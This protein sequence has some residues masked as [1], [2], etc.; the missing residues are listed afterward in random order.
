M[1]NEENIAS[2]IKQRHLPMNKLQTIFQSQEL[3]ILSS[4]WF[5]LIWGY[6]NKYGILQDFEELPLIPIGTEQAFKEVAVLRKSSLIIHYE[7]DEEDGVISLLRHL[8]C[9]IV[10]A[11]PSYVRQNR[12]VFECKY[13]YDYKDEDLLQL[14]S[15]LSLKLGQD[16][17]IRKFSEFSGREVKLEFFRKVSNFAVKDSM[18]TLIKSLPFIENT[19]DERL[20][21]VEQCHLIAP[22]ELPDVMPQQM[23]LRIQHEVQVSFIEKLGGRQLNKREFI[24]A[25]L[26]PEINKSIVPYGNSQSMINY[27]LDIIAASTDKQQWQKVINALSSVR[28]VQSDDGKL[29]K[30]IELFRR[31]ERLEKLFVGEKGLFPNIGQNVQV[32]KLKNVS[33]VSAD[34]IRRS[35]VPIHG[36]E[37]IHIAQDK[38]RRVLEHLEHYSNLLNDENLIY[39]LTNTSWIPINKKRPDAY[40]DSLT[41][42]GENT[43]CNFG[44][45]AEMITKKNS[46]LVGSVRAVIPSDIEDFKAVKLIMK[47]SQVTCQDVID[48]LLHVITYDYNEKHKVMIVLDEIYRYLQDMCNELTPKQ[49]KCLKCKR[50]VWCGNC[51][52]KPQQIVLEE[53]HLDMQP[54]IYNLPQDLPKMNSLLSICGSVA[55]IGKENLMHVLHFIK[56]EQKHHTSSKE[57]IDRDRRICVDVLRDLGH[58]KLSD[59]D[60]NRILVPIRC[61]DTELLL[62]I[63]TQ[64]VYSPIGGLN[65]EEEEE[66][67]EED[68]IFLHECITEDIVKGLRIRSLTSQRIGAEDLGIEEFGQHEPLTRRINRILADY[69]DGLAIMKELIQNAD[70]AG[71]VEVKFLYDE[72]L[73]E[74]KQKYL[75]DPG[76]KGIQ[77]PALWAYNDAKFSKED[78]DN[79]VKLS[80]ATKEDKRDKIGKFGLGFNAVYNITDVPSFISDNQL[81]ILDPH[82]T[83]LG[84]AI[85]NKSKPGVKIPLGPKR[86]R[87]RAFQDQIRIYDGIFGMDAS[88][89]EG[90][91]MF[92][93]TLF[94]FPLRTER[95]AQMSE[96]KKLYYS[97]DEMKKLIRKFSNEANRL[98]MFTQNVLTVEFFH[99]EEGT[100]NAESMRRI[101]HVS[102]KIFIPSIVHGFLTANGC[103]SFDIMKQA[104]HAVEYTANDKQGMLFARSLCHVIE[105]ATNADEGL[106]E[107]FEAESKYENETWLIH[108]S[109]DDKECMKMALENPQLNPVASVAVCIEKNEDSKTYK[110]LQQQSSNAGH[111]YCF[112]P[113]PIPNGLNVHINS[114]FAL[115]KDRKSFLERSEDDKMHETLETIWNRQ[116]ISGPVSSAYIGLLKD[117]TTLIDLEDETTWY[118]LWPQND[119]VGSNLLSYK[120]ELTR[121]FYHNIIKD[122][123]C[124]FPHSN[125]R[126]VWLNW[127]QILTIED[128]VRN[129][130][131]GDVIERMMEEVVCSFHKEKIVVH[132]PEDLLSTLEKSGFQNELSIIMLSF[133]KFFVEIFMPVVKKRQISLGIIEVILV[134]AI[135]NFSHDLS[136]NKS[137]K[138]CECIPTKPS[139]GLRKPSDLVMPM[140]KA[141]DLFEIDEQVFPL[142]SFED[143]YGNLMKLGMLSDNISI[144]FLIDRAKT[145]NTLG[146]SKR[147]VAEKR[148]RKII[149]LL[150]ER[151]SQTR[152]DGPSYLWGSVKFLPA[153]PKPPKWLLLKCNGIQSR[154]GFVSAGE[155]YPSRLE[156]VIG[157]HKL[158]IDND[159]TG[160][161]SPAVEKLLGVRTQVTVHDIISQVDSISEYIRDREKSELPEILPDVFDMIYK[162]LWELLSEGSLLEAEI[163]E[164]FKDRPVILTNKNTLVKPKQVAFY[165]RYNAEPYLYSLPSRFAMSYRLLMTALGVKKTFSMEDYNSALSA[166][167]KYAGGSPLSDSQL[168]TVR[169]LLESVDNEGTPR[170]N[171]IFLPDKD[172]VLRKKDL[173]VVKERV[174]MR[175]DPTKRYLHDRIPP[176]LALSLGTKTERSHSIAS[177]SR[178]LPFGQHEKLTVRLK[179]ILEAYSSQMQILYEL[180]QNADDAGASEVKF[181]LDKRHHA[182]EKVFGDAWKSLQG[183]ALLVFNDAPFT[184]RD[185]EGIQNLGEGS[186]SDDCQKT[187]QYGI[188]FNVVYHVTDAPCLLARVEDDSVLCIF[189][190]HARF[191]DECSEAEPG[192]MFTNGRKY[193][194]NTFPD[195]YN[196]FLPE[197]LAN[198]KSAIL[199]LPLR[200]RFHA[201]NSSIKQIDTNPEE[202]LEM[203]QSFKDKGP[204]AI[205][206]LR[207]VKS[208]EIFI[209]EDTSQ[210]EEPHSMFSVHADMT[211][212]SRN[213]LSSFNK[214]YKSLSSSIGNRSKSSRKYL[215][216]QCEITLRTNKESGREGKIK[217]KRQKVKEKSGDTTW[218]IIQKCASINPEDLPQPLDDQYKNG[219]LPLIPVGGIAH[220][221]DGS[222]SDGKVYCLLPLAVSSS[223]PLHMNGKFIL[224][225]ESRRRL[226]YTNEN[227]F[228]KTWN[229]YVIEHCIVPCYVQL[230]RTLAHERN[231]VFGK[232]GS[233]KLLENALKINGTHPEEIETYFCLFPKIRIQE[234][235]HE[236]EADLIKMFYQRLTSKEVNVLPV[237]RPSSKAVN[238]EFC[239]PNSKIKQFYYISLSDQ[240]QFFQRHSSDICI[241]LVELGM[242]IYNIPAD[243]VQS[244]SASDV[245]LEKLT[246]QVVNEFLRSKAET[247]LK[248]KEQLTLKCSVF[249]NITTVKAL[250]QY[251]AKCENFS[252]IGLPL[253]VTEDEVL[254]RFDDS[255]HVYYDWVSILF[256]SRTYMALHPKLG[257]ILERFMDKTS[258]A[259]RK[260]MLD[261]FSQLMH[262]GLGTDFMMNDE[263]VVD[264]SELNEMLPREDWLRYAWRFLQERFLEWKQHIDEENKRVRKIRTQKYWQAAVSCRTPREMGLLRI[265][266]LKRVSEWCIFPVERHNRGNNPSKQY[267][268][269]RISKASNAVAAGTGMNHVVD[270]LSLPVPSSL[271]VNNHKNHVF[272]NSKMLMDMATNIEDVNAFIDALTVESKREE[273]G[274]LGLSTEISTEL[275]RFLSRKADDI[276]QK[277]KVPLKNL[278]VWEDLSGE[279]KTISSTDCCYL[280]S[281]MIPKDGTSLLQDRH[282]VLLLKKHP[283]LQ[284]I[285]RIIALTTENDTNVYCNLILEHFDE[286]KP[287]DR[288]AHL[289]YLKDKCM[290]SDKPLSIL[291][292]KLNNTRIIEKNGELLYAKDFYD[293]DIKLFNVML[294][295]SDFPPKNL[296]SVSW[297]HFLR[298]S[299]LISTVS[300]DL[301]CKFATE[302]SQMQ[303]KEDGRRKSSALIEYFRESDDLKSDSQ[304]LKLLSSIPFLVADKLNVQLSKIHPGENEEGMVCFNGSALHS[305]RNIM[306]SWTVENT[307]PSYASA[308]PIHINLPYDSLLAKREV[309]I[310]TVARNLENISNS[311]LLR[312]VAEGVKAY[313]KCKKIDDIFD[314]AYEYLHKLQPLENDDAVS[315][316]CTI[317]LVLV[318]GNMISI[319]NK[320][321]M[322]KEF[323]IPPYLFSMNLSLGKFADLFKR[324]GMSEKPTIYQLINVLDGLFSASNGNPLGP[325]EA[326]NC[327]KVI[328]RFMDL[329]NEE[330][331]PEDISLLRLPGC[332]G[333]EKSTV[334]LFQSQD[335]VYYDDEHIEERLTKLKQPKLYLDFM[336]EPVSL[337]K[338]KLTHAAVSRFITKLPSPLQPKMIRTIV[339]EVIVDS[340]TI[341]NFG[342][343]K[344]LQIVMKCIEFAEC[345]IRLLKHQEDGSLNDSMTDIQKISELLSRV[346]VIT[347]ESV[348]TV[349][350]LQVSGERVDGSEYENEVFAAVHEERL[351]IYVSSSLTKKSDTIAAVASAL[352]SFFHFKDPKLSPYIN[353]LLE[354]D[355]REMHEYLDKQRIGRY[356]KDIAALGGLFYSLGGYVP[357]ELHCLLVNDISLFKVGD[358]VAY[359]V[360]DPGLDD[361]DGDPV[362]IYAK[363]LECITR[364][365]LNDFY[366]IDIGV[367]EPKIVHKSELYGFYRPDNFQEDSEDGPLNVEKVKE[368]IRRELEE[369]F[370]HGEEY[371]KRI[372][373]RLWLRWHPDKNIG[374]EEFCTEIFK[375]IQAEVVRLP[376]NRSEFFWNSESSFKRYRQRGSM[377]SQ[378][379]SDFKMNNRGYSWSGGYWRASN[380]SKNPQPGEAKRWFRQA[381]FDLEAAGS[382]LAEENYEWLCFKCHQVC[383]QCISFFF[384]CL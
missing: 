1:L 26:L 384:F 295:E 201:L 209:I 29:Y 379:K 294:M 70:D 72:R 25:V 259:L 4:S 136:V 148:V 355:Q 320:V 218:R 124:V 362:Y 178:G 80:G 156:N 342:F 43:L 52:V 79:I 302:I 233:Q 192:R 309:S 147:D 243:I 27:I 382:D 30:P 324:M 87:L 381:K 208:V 17:V 366:K 289:S 165:L 344:D 247:V 345:M 229:Y 98:L 351:E 63:S 326:K 132:V 83:H 316:L 231:F 102:K 313:S 36:I 312:S 321:T 171:D 251:C 118:S 62:E 123:L 112:L 44:K 250:L 96:I 280:I 319:A 329:L 47:S 8:S 109:I 40:P 205:I 151:I 116:L 183:P 145:V 54:Y 190:P 99:L 193:L 353:A 265:N 272:D 254:R 359:E 194:K 12:S 277:S 301:F 211:D 357:I 88:L 349:L 252:L 278:P 173:V 149:Q 364:H 106:K 373:K 227:T 143:C 212:E 249:G 196:T 160:T 28:F 119:A 367:E 89:L 230:L 240:E 111:F 75:I 260:F 138:E 115:S 343:T 276:D 97:K 144:E 221:T 71:A 273:S 368:S 371:A 347:K 157:C 105:I 158:V 348:R 375:F 232:R 318:N 330:E 34:D 267:F 360:E 220:K 202:I 126:N 176:K 134:F 339:K 263:M 168:N 216:F 131:N 166:M 311:G 286:L 354:K 224:D 337:H 161:M 253:L 352:V 51:F 113:L 84:H 153:K 142:E 181:I 38:A 336:R 65:C 369:A 213:A 150:E 323:D 270:G 10:K 91:K 58:M 114:T 64:A 191:L 107:L 46:T 85:K 226:W 42:Y 90:Y 162:K 133:P 73:S 152:D 56:E 59:D 22:K 186:K 207:N 223:L 308:S 68:P 219:N 377:F 204:E 167:E 383:L 305:D 48:Q 264:V 163:Q 235:A 125:S 300:A 60:L 298:L 236:Y 332:Y 245:P 376:G 285:Y 108:S 283:A 92:K 14:L 341:P 23:L 139:G 217:R 297:L 164:R 282:K 238:V 307:L 127:T 9:T 179:R 184:H 358:Y 296:R 94:R 120:Q 41:W 82:T 197:F 137:I 50:W 117:L 331:F 103:Q 258:G 225:Y 310:D 372:R 315:I 187:G 287:G 129:M 239:P 292:E 228:Q 200:S 53:Y 322:E 338:D 304:F 334:C 49:L 69:G 262:E 7:R 177:Q 175:N 198:E 146:D 293:P 74:D 271:L 5:P 86:N 299:G 306:L 291:L 185:I 279:L 328:R 317:P 244:F 269:I 350:V 266:F 45:P 182:D 110:L 256:P 55:E 257:T 380:D 363:V 356:D 101:L 140:S 361:N 81:V 159:I 172:K 128:S 374:N 77:G 189:D 325:N 180:L 31:C 303:D 288:F 234:K 37:N 214:D 95:Q 199:R 20:V 284:S 340:A 203:F 141:A 24:K 121:S 195:I 3:T 35:L 169:D 61:E 346:E 13:I 206:F 248:G 210:A 154:E 18:Q 242:N 215:P 104:S 290:T 100:K 222:L 2:L 130:K 33:D 19:S 78:F 333:M 261:D 281:E 16:E 93:G 255:K 335:L 174:W 76:M 246:P 155:I 57:E 135:Q 268:L 314:T 11:L 275:L 32:L 378:Q 170:P 365:T 370:Q 241:A 188:G 327:L 66:E 6:I 237:L 15:N 21:S 274:F 39:E 122:Q 67:G